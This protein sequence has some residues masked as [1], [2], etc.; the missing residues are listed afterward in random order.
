MRRGSAPGL[1]PQRPQRLQYTAP[2]DD[3]GVVHASEDVDE[4]PELGPDASR[5]ER[6]RAE[7]AARK[8]DERKR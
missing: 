3:G 1:T 2:S 6:R 8:R 7:R 5:A 4:V